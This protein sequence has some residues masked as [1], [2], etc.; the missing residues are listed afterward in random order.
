MVLLQ[1]HRPYNGEQTKLQSINLMKC[2]LKGIQIVKKIFCDYFLTGFT[3]LPLI[4]QL[5]TNTIK[6]LRLWLY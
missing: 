3:T 1:Q 4:F 6:P 5:I 2:I